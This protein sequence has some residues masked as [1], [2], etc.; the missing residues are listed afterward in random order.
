MPRN[1]NYDIIRAIAI[2]MVMCI[3]C[4]MPLKDSLV[5]GSCALN[6]WVCEFYYALISAGVPMFFMLSGA[7]LLGKLEPWLEFYKKRLKRIIIPF[8]IWSVVVYSLSAFV[9]PHRDIVFYLKDFF[10]LLCTKGVNAAYWFV[11]MLLGFYLITPLCRR[12]VQK[13]SRDYFWVGTI[14]IIGL[15][16]I[17][18]Y[19][20]LFFPIIKEPCRWLCYFCFYVGGYFFSQIHSPMQKQW[21]SIVFISILLMGYTI[22]SVFQIRYIPC[23]FIYAFSLF[24]CLNQCSSEKTIPNDV[25][26]VF[27]RNGYGIY[28]SH[29]IFCGILMRV[30]FFLE[31]VPLIVLPLIATTIVAIIEYG[32]MCVIEKL[33]WNRWLC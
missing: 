10:T 11:Y 23:T 22:C 20:S 17:G 27:S 4:M 8:V 15:Y 21:S 2:L 7:L 28:L 16:L 5:E 31:H 18:F 33:G 32:M 6:I 12:L 26:S 24:I 9:Q 19:L 1:R 3:H 14:G 29:V 13:L 30:P 25:I